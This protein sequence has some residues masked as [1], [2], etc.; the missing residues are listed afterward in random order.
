MPQEWADHYPLNGEVVPKDLS[1]NWYYSSDKDLIAKYEQIKEAVQ[2]RNRAL[3]RIGNLTLVT[4]PLNSAMQNGP[5]AGKKVALKNSLLLINR[6]FDT[7]DA[8]DEGQIERR[9]KA[10]F[11]VAKQLWPRV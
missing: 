3:Q 11:Q 2:A 10:L 5:F 7:V 1:R 6:Y 9:S 8:W 4:Q